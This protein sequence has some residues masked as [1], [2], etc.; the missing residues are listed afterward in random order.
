MECHPAVFLSEPALP[1]FRLSL[2]WLLVLCWSPQL[3]AQAVEST[4]AGT[5]APRVGLVLGGGGARGLAHVGVL[6]VLEA[7][8]VHVDAVAGTS[9][10]AIIGGLYAAGY[11]ASQIEQI[12]LGIDWERV[13]SDDAARQQRAM[14][15]KQDDRLGLIGASA[16]LKDGKLVLPAGILTGQQISLLLQKLFLPRADVRDFDRLP[17]PFRAVATDIVTGEA[18]IMRQGNLAEAI[19]AS[20]N[21]P[22]IFAPV[23]WKGHQLVDGGLVNNLPVTVMRQ[24]GVDYIIAVPVSAPMLGKDKLGSLIDVTDQLTRM[25]IAENESYQEDFL[26]DAD[27]LIRPDLRAIGSGDFDKARLAIAQGRKA[28]Q[29]FLSRFRQWREREK[30]PVVPMRA[31]A[32]T[33]VDLRVENDLPLAT[34]TVL[35]QLHQSRGQPLDVAQLEADIER[36]YGT[37]LYQKISWRLENEPAGHV[38]VVTLQGKAWGPSYLQ[39]GLS[40]TNNFTGDNAYEINLRYLRTV[41]NPLGGEAGVYVRLGQNPLLEVDGYQPL[42][43]KPGWFVAARGGYRKTN[44]QVYQQGALLSNYRLTHYGLE[45]SLGYEWGTDWRLQTTLLRE[46]GHAGLEIGF[47]IVSDDQPLNNAHVRLGLLHDSLDSL[48][49]PTSGWLLRARWMTGKRWMGSDSNYQAVHLQARVA[50]HLPRQLLWLG[51]EWFGSSSEDA[52]VPLLQRPT[53]GGFLRLSGMQ[54]NQLILGENQWL[55]NA[56]VLQDIRPWLGLRSL[57]VPVYLGASLEAG[58][59]R[60]REHTPG[61]YRLIRSGSLFLGVDTWVG[62]V[63][64]GYGR[65]DQGDEAVFFH[66]NRQFG[67]R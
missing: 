43:A 32:Q 7:Q 64:L 26:T 42:S 35:Q 61:Q 58:R 59:S 51:G 65:T 60:N 23:E 52:G 50:A 8:G 66:L 30:S 33:I 5:A 55:L 4:P 41:L 22:G 16:G 19:R 12:A 14:Q 53:L 21:V 9:M 34:E 29:A 56:A 25:M 28:A 63:F 3:S 11:S 15:R 62:P 48:Y 67:E 13:F 37:G 2:L 27:V 38:L 49:F 46:R 36:L 1:V 47:P 40:L 6:Q 57:P 45:A 17:I 24:M 10:G 39:T 44:V 20:M 18:V 31:K 54:E